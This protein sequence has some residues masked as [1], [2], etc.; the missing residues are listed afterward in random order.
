MTRC[1]RWDSIQGMEVTRAIAATRAALA[2]ARHGGRRIAFVPTM[3][4]LHVAHVS[5]MEAAKRDGGYLVVSIFVNP[6]QF[7]PG[8]DFA[9][10]PRDEAGDLAVCETA[11]VDL[12][13]MPAAE[14]VHPAGS[15][16]TVHVARLTETLCGPQRPG[17][18]DGVATVV[19]KLFNIVQPDAAYFGQKDAQ[20]LAVIRQMVRDLN[21]PIEIVGCP[22][23]READGLAASSRNAYLEGSQR[24]QARCLYQALCEAKSRIERGETLAAAVVRA[25]RRIIEAAGPAEIDYISVADPETM[26]PVERIDRPVLVALA[27]RIGSTRLIDNLQ[28]DPRDRRD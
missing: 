26:Q 24:G 27:V 11:G 14:E 20:Q 18:F 4:A 2:A 3:G 15:V 23:V 8:E 28:V 13:F 22:T 1:G 12:V 25:M 16:T 5:L 21:M 17:H 9:R 6:T 10:Y 7:A 19:A